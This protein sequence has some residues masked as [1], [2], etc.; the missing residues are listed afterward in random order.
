MGAGLLVLVIAAFLGYAHYRAHRFLAALPEKLGADIRQE[1]NGFTYSQSEGG[2]TIYTIHASKAI[3]HKDGRYTLHDVGIVLYGR[4]GDRAD[5]IY[6]S[7]FD[8]DQ[9]NGVVRAM[10]E[11]HLDLQAPVAKSAGAKMDYAAGKD[12]A[13]NQEMEGAHLIHV[14]TSGLVYL[15]KLGV[16]A[17]DQPIEFEANGMKGQAVGADYTADSGVLILH[18]A[19]RMAGLVHGSPAVLTAVRAELDRDNKQVRL[20]NARYVSNGKDSATTAQADHAVV[21][22]RSDGTVQRLDADG[23]VTLTQAGES[24]SA[25]HGVV[26]LSG[27]NNPESATMTGGVTLGANDP[28]RVAHGTASEAKLAFD[29]AGRPEHLLLTGQVHLDE[30]VRVSTK[31]AAWSRRELHAEEA[32]LVLGATAADKTFVRDAKASGNAMLAVTNPPAKR[33]RT[34]KKMSGTS[35]TASATLAADVLTAHFNEADGSQH[36]ANVYG[37]GHASFRRADEA[38]TIQ[39]SLA[40]SLVAFF[41]PAVAGAK[42]RTGEEVG[43]DELVSALEQGHVR[44]TQTA[45]NKAGAARAPA[46]ET[47]TADRA[48][49]DGIL[50][51]AVLTGNV[52]MTDAGSML[53]ADH[54]VVDQKTGDATADGDVKLT[55]LEPASDHE[56]NTGAE[57]PVHVLA[58][59]AEVQH[60]SG[61]ATFYG[62]SGGRARLW[63]GSSQIEAPVIQF[64]RNKKQMVAHG[65]GQGV[66]MAVRAVLASPARTTDRTKTTAPARENVFVVTSRQLLYS[67]EKREADFTGG[68][69]VMSADGRMRGE[70]AVVYLQPVNKTVPGAKNTARNGFFGGSVERMVATGDIVIEQPGRRATGQQVVYTASDGNFALTGTATVPP[71]V[72]DDQ[73]GTVTGTLLQFRTGDESVVVSNGGKG[74][75]ARVRTQTQ[76]KKSR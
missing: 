44:L 50:N 12:L 25:P 38:G 13:S 68:I 57:Q 61:I 28:L 33:D 43:A 75:A 51:R 21:H 5:R 64:D 60:S 45:A 58:V 59:H 15:Q 34:G 54:V 71:T 10:G 49:Y 22:L 17:T 67:D 39:T 14:T 42:T 24:V 18:S 63:Q 72:V 46:E 73:R 48:S 31:Q 52:Q 41:Q 70:Q 56:K 19:V 66:L 32:Q 9:K 47:A 2:R 7:E 3:Q 6:G 1:T 40:D 29:K 69:E 27:D 74:S 65:A 11:V 36:L 53:W 4:T 30:Q 55:Y 62:A 8:Y 35:G 37:D 26:V 23:G 20:L 16:A 76:V